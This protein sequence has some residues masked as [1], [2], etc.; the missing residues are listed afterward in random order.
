MTSFTIDDQKKHLSKKDEKIAFLGQVY[1]EQINIMKKKFNFTGDINLLLSGDENTKE[2]KFIQNLKDSLE[3]NIRN[4][5]NLH[6][7]QKKIEEQEEE[8]KKL[9]NKEQII[10]SNDTL[11]KYYISVQQINEEK[12]RK[13]KDINKLRIEKEELNKKLELKDKIIEKYKKEIEDKNKILFNLPQKLKDSYIYNLSDE[14]KNKTNREINIGEAILEEENNNEKNESLETDNLY[15]KE[16]ERIKKENQ[17]NIIILKLN[18]DNLIKEKENIIKKLE[19]NYE[20]L[21]KDKYQ[22]LNKYGNEIIK[23]NKILMSLISNYK[24]IYDSNLTERLSIINFSLKKEEFDKIIMSVDKDINCN[25]FPLLYQSLIKTN[26]LKTTQPLLYTNYKKIYSPLHKLK[27]YKEVKIKKENIIENELKNIVGANDEEINN[28]F[29]EETNKGNLIFSKEQLE[30]MSKEEI[31][32]HC[33][34]INN[35]F[36]GIENYLAKYTKYKK[37]FNVEE[38][39]MGEKYKE[40]IIEELK[41][42]IKKLSINLDEQVKTNNKNIYIINTQ[43]RKID[44]L[45]KEAIIYNNILNHKNHSSSIISPN[46]STIYNSSAIEFNSINSNNSISKNNKSLK[47]SSSLINAKKIKQPFSPRLRKKIYNNNV[48]NGYDRQFSPKDFTINKL[49]NKLYLA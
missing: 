23:L 17:K 39:E 47:K 12:N 15:T 13:D 28:F 49:K 1:Q 40:K 7:L 3:K 19:S 29:K 11:I 34:N 26:Q 30:K 22:D 44:K 37:G 33:I 48:K 16:I 46:K 25:N 20:I 27:D 5:G 32:Q 6:L 2:A 41:E 38:F 43:N 14:N 31:I 45:Q 4:E 21:K 36:I 42:K 9:K 8:I 35:K 24:R 18:Y 10:D